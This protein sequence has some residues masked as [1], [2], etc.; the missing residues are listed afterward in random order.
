[1]EIR[2]D[3]TTLLELDDTAGEVAGWGPIIS[4]LARQI[5]HHQIGSQWTVVVTDPDTGATV[6]TGVTRRR[7]TAAQRRHITARNSTCVFKGCRMP[8]T[9]CQIDHTID[10][11]QGGPTHTSNLGPLCAHDHLTDKHKAGWKLTQPQPG[12]FVWTSPRGHTY[13]VRPPP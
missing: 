7:P 4:D 11:A 9:T 5:V 2:V 1:M 3:L 13:L 10:Y 6:H 12:V 8:S